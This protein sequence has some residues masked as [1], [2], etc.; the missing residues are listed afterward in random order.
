MERF[1][2]SLPL[3]YALLLDFQGQISRGPATLYDDVYEKM[4]DE[5]HH[6]Y[7]RI[8]STLL[9]PFS[10]QLWTRLRYC[11]YHRHGIFMLIRLKPLYLARVS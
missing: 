8:S 6:G 5:E 3:R 9:T 2:G 4:Y 10:P 11:R 7:P 1:F